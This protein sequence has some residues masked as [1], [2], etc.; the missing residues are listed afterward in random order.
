MHLWKPLIP[1]LQVILGVGFRSAAVVP[2]LGHVEVR[3][4]LDYQV[5]SVRIGRTDPKSPPQTPAFKAKARHFTY[6]R[7]TPI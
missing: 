1:W 2:P 6:R 7:L 3:D 4:D 5:G